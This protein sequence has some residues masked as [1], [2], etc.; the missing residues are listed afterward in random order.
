MKNPTLNKTG[1]NSV[2]LESRLLT[3]VK[4]R[5]D[6]DDPE[7]L[8]NAEVGKE[9]WRVRVNDFPKEH[10]YTLFVD[11]NELGSFDEWPQ[12]WEHGVGTMRST[13]QVFK[14]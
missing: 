4:W 12:P 6:T 2:G 8:W 11:G 5:R 10:L 9:T 3:P 14:S 1:D 7:F 13:R